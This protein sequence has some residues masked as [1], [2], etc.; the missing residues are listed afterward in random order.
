MNSL[1]EVMAANGEQGTVT[2]TD[3][4]TSMLSAI[5]RNRPDARPLPDI[6]AF[7]H[8]PPAT[9]DAFAEAL[10]LMGGQ[11]DATFNTRQPDADSLGAYIRELFPQ[12]KRICSAIE[13][14]SGVEQLNREAAPYALEDVDVAIV[15]ARFGVAE[16]GS[17]WL[18]EE[19]LGINTLGYLAQHLVV[20]L[21]PQA[22]V[23][24][25]HAAYARDDFT[26]VHYAVLMSGPSAT[27]DIE[28]ILIRG[29]QGVRSLHVLA[30]PQDW[31]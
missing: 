22:I 5:R 16:T 21:D 8:R 18:S 9:A 26:S 2:T 29:A 4:R 14:I 19:E 23:S 20:L 6:P 10:A 30:C 25:L 12:A 27:A 31:R 17:V 15:R 11:R 1:Q 7:E 28:G 3:A 24:D 13:G